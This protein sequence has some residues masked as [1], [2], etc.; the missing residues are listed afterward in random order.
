M[1]KL[2]LVVKNFKNCRSGLEEL[3][4]GHHGLNVLEENV[5]ELLIYAAKKGGIHRA[6]QK[7]FG[8][9]MMFWI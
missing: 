9:K 1:S 7:D 5:R 2:G 4:K 3:G 6:C 8:R